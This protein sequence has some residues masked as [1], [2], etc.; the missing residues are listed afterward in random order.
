[1]PAPQTKSPISLRRGTVK[2]PMKHGAPISDR[3]EAFAG[4]TTP[5]Y[6]LVLLSCGVGKESGDFAKLFGHPD[7]MR[8]YD[9]REANLVHVLCGRADCNQDI[10]HR[11]A[12]DHKER[13]SQ[14]RNCARGAES[15]ARARFS[16][17]WPSHN[18]MVW[19]SDNCGWR[20]ICDSAAIRRQCPVIRTIGDSSMTSFVKLDVSQKMTAICVVDNAGRRV[21]R[22]QCPTIPEQI[23]IW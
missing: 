22:D 4:Q 23:S 20:L 10:R 15:T 13:V 3:G 14:R 18:V 5:S 9:P 7:S 17:S 19:T 16:R 8:Q 11:L 6:H 1:M 2:L 12:D 21:W